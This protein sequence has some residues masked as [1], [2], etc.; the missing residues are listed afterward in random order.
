[1]KEITFE[2]L[3]GAYVNKATLDENKTELKLLTDKGDFVLVTEAD[4]CSSSW[5]EHINIEDLIDSKILEMENVY[6]QGYSA[7]PY[8]YKTDHE[9][10]EHDCLQYYCLKMKTSKGYVDIEYRNSSNGYYGGSIRIEKF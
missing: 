5:I 2:S 4:C 3:I 8:A 6:M 7:H 1:M 9:H 10:K